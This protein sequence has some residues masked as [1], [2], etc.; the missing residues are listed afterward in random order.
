LGEPIRSELHFDTFFISDRKL[1]TQTTKGKKLKKWKMTTYPIYDDMAVLV[2][3]TIATGIGVFCAGQGARVSPLL[4]DL[5]DTGFHAPGSEEE[6]DESA[7]S[8]TE[9]PEVRLFSSC[10][11][12]TIMPLNR[13]LPHLPLSHNLPNEA[14]IL[15]PVS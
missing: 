2:D 4:D 11:L 9:D 10:N 12:L 7:K 8:V 1:A 5:E 14:P 6:G 15:L 3:G 13:C